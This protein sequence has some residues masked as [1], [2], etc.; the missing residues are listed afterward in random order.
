MNSFGRLRIFRC[1]VRYDGRLCKCAGNEPHR[2]SARRPTSTPTGPS[3]M[4]DG[5]P[6]YKIQVVAREIP[7]INYFHRQGCDQDRLRG[8]RTA[9]GGE[10]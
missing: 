8:H 1:F 2:D 6:V 9:A 5:V 10:G 3:E 4:Q 7:A